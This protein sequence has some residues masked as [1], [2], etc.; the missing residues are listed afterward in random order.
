MNNYFLKL[1]EYSILEN[2]HINK[3][4]EYMK[5]HPRITV[6]APASALLLLA[7]ASSK[8]KREVPSYR[9]SGTDLSSIYSPLKGVKKGEPYF[10]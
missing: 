5:R 6:M 7:Y 3:I 9:N 4:T 2:M 1:Q 10:V 8:A